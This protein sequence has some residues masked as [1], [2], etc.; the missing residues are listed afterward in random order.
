[1]EQL[2]ETAVGRQ[3][4]GYDSPSSG[5]GSL[6]V[7]Q[8]EGYDSPS[9]GVG[10]LKVHSTSCS[11]LDLCAGGPGGGDHLLPAAHQET[12][13]GEDGDGEE[14]TQGAGINDARHLAII[15]LV[16][17]STRQEQH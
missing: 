4:E 10:S 14:Q 2:Q 5:V 9:S 8:E 16:K 12:L 3:E 7:R 1:M 15:M 11:S 17:R 13:G 6:K